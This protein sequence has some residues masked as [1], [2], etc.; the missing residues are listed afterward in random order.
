MAYV[1][2]RFG[3]PAVRDGL[4]ILKPH[5]G[6]NLGRAIAAAQND[7]VVLQELPQAVGHWV[8][9]PQTVGRAV[10][11]AEIGVGTAVASSFGLTEM[12]R[13]GVKFVGQ[14]LL[15]FFSSSYR[16]SLLRAR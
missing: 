15:Y 1:A 3:L 4:E 2:Y 16:A 8:P 14:G 9:D 13:S 10:L 12:L 11:T 6:E 5:V 7:T